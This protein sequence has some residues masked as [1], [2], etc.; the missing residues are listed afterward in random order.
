MAEMVVQ[1]RFRVYLHGFSDHE[2]V[3]PTKAKAKYRDWRAAEDAGYFTGSDG[4]W[5]YLINVR[6]E[7]IVTRYT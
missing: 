5:R 2:I 7:E 4:F 1:R 3:A 6:L